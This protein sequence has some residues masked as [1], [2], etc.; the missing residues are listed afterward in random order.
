MDKKRYYP[1]YKSM[2]AWREVWLLILVLWVVSAIV[3]ILI[4]LFSE[5]AFAGDN[6]EIHDEFD[7]DIGRLGEQIR[8]HD[9]LIADVRV[10]VAHIADHGHPD[11]EHRIRTLEAE[12]ERFHGTL[13]VIKG[14]F[15]FI[16]AAGALIGVVPIVRSVRQHHQHMPPNSHK[17]H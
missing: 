16:A 3:V 17:D 5:S 1:K 4:I 14:L 15:V 6:D 7:S 12:V 13:S 2:D 8:E 9:K 10:E 11:H